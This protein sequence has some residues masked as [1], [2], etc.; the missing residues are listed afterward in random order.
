MACAQSLPWGLFTLRKR[1][2]YAVGT[3]ICNVRAP[4]GGS[5]PLD[6]SA[7]SRGLWWRGEV[8]WGPLLGGQLC[9]KKTSFW[10]FVPKTC[11]NRGD[12]L[13]HHS[14]VAACIR[15]ALL[16]RRCWEWVPFRP[17][18]WGGP[19]V[20][21]QCLV[22]S[23]GALKEVTGCND[24][25]LKILNELLQ[26]I[27]VIKFYAWEALFVNR[28]GAKREE[29]LRAGFFFFW[30]RCPG[31][32]K[33][34]G[35]GWVMAVCLAFWFADNSTAVC[36]PSIAQAVTF[37]LGAQHLFWRAAPGGLDIR[38]VLGFRWEVSRWRSGPHHCS[39]PGPPC[40]PP[41]G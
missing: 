11:R 8:G 27:K 22:W 38:K 21:T 3:A 31:I 17:C 26:G 39:T 16:G 37:T 13:L 35:M 28:I 18:R 33:G 6:S 23:F 24:A 1:K 30:P 19:T 29:Q 32:G 10:H 7:P 4:G 9:C 20:V 14:G 34:Y 25:R 36:F 12:T 5:G 41:R 2:N 40:P 15:L